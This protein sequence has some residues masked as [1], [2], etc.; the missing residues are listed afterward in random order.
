MAGA[1]VDTFDEEPYTGLLTRYENVLLT[2]HVGS[3]TAE[4]RVDMEREAVENLLAGLAKAGV[5]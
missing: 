4:S 3:N 2:P 5:R 1:W